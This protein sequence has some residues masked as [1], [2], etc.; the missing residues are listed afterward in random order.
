M[1]YG[2][3]KFSEGE[4]G[5]VPQDFV[6]TNLFGLPEKLQEI[7]NRYEYIIQNRSVPGLNGYI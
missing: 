3:N 2:L 1:S 6:K 7:M 4:K 5:R